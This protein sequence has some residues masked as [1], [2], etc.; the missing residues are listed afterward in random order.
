MHIFK[1]LPK[2]QSHQS[3]LESTTSVREKEYHL[4]Q[5]PLPLLP[6]G[7]LGLKW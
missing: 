4:K 6:E 7:K 1:Q 5:R 3:L 2:V